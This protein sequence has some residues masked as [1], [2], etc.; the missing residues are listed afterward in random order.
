MGNAHH[1]LILA[2]REIVA[3]GLRAFMVGRPESQRVLDTGEI[4]GNKAASRRVFRTFRAP[5]GRY[6]YGRMRPRIWRRNDTHAANI[7]VR[8]DFARCA[9]TPGNSGLS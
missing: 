3:S 4:K 7:A 6:Q 8:I 5:A 9:E 1:R 2:G